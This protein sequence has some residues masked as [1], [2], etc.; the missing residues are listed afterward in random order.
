MRFADTFVR[1]LAFVGLVTLALIT[2]MPNGATR[3]HATP[4]IFAQAL[5]LAAPLLALGLRCFSS[6]SFRLP[7]AAWVWFV[8][9]LALVICAATFAS[10]YRASSLWVAAVPLAAIAAFFLGY[11]WLQSDSAPRHVQVEK[12]LGWSGVALAV[13]SNLLWAADAVRLTKAEFFSRTLFEV[14]NPHPLGHSNYTAGLMLFFLPWIIRRISHERGALRSAAIAGASLATFALFMSGSRGG[15]IGAV[16]LGVVMAFS[17]N[18]PRRRTLLIGASAVLAALILGAINP[19]IRDMFGPRDPLAAP[20][21]SNVQRSAMIDAG[22]EMIHARPLFGWGPGATPFAY[23]QFRGSLGGGPENVLQLHCTP[24]HVWAE[25]GT[26][27]IIVVAGLCVILF[28]RRVWAVAALA[29][30]AVFSFT[31][32]QLDVPI[33]PF[34]LAAVVALAAPPQTNPCSRR[35]RVLLGG[36]ALIILL[37]IAQAGGRDHASALS[38]EALTLAKN[39]AQRDRAIALFNETLR[40]N[41]HQ[42][43]AHFNLGWLLLAENT[44]AAESHFLET[45]RLVPDKGGAYF[46]L[47]L[48][49]LAQENLEGTADAFALECINDPRFL[50]SPWWR[51]PFMAA[52]RKRTAQAYARFLAAFANYRYLS[53]WEESQV[54]LLAT[55]TGQL[56]Q[57]SSN[58]ERS[59]RRERTGYPVLMRNPDLGTPTDLYDV[60]EDARFAESLPFPLPPKGWLNNWALVSLLKDPQQ[61]RF[62]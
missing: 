49:R 40:L 20:N 13:V 42:E 28:R 32:F 39:P 57:P 8:S 36:M 43:I 44:V 47:G 4:W 30:Y 12:I 24:L 56:G 5:A 38:A 48:A 16:A 46:G 19:R 29:G 9:A 26:V 61:L 25:T 3:M 22:V 59:Y 6:K 7:S 55:L 27:G 45:L 50:A 21:L 18:F 41:P 60:R 31:D 62:P 23:P 10:P 14:R 37:V 17:S 11:D 52:Q 1:P 15:L 53:P 54:K 34:G 2:L 51:E 33:F 35:S 58:Q